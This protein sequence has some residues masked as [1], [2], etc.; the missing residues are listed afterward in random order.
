VGL[1]ISLAISRL[2]KTFRIA[3]VFAVCGKNLSWPVP[4]LKSWKKIDTRRRSYL[5]QQIIEKPDLPARAGMAP[6][7]H[8]AAMRWEYEKDV[9]PR[10]AFGGILRFEISTESPK[11]VPP[12]KFAV[13][14]GSRFRTAVLF[15]AYPID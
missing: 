7:R 10:F 2:E 12:G 3:I 9:R 8:S 5:R 6:F 13:S 15:D 4:T 11:P 14:I 1:C